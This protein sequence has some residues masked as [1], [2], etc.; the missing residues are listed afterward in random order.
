MTRLSNPLTN[1][2]TRVDA[3]K[4]SYWQVSFP[5]TVTKFLIVPYFH[6]LRYRWSK[7]K[8]VPRW[9]G[10]TK[11]HLW[12]SC[13]CIEGIRMCPMQ[14]SHYILLQLFKRIEQGEGNTQCLCTADINVHIPIRDT[15]CCQFSIFRLAL[16]FKL[17]FLYVQKHVKQMN[18]SYSWISRVLYLTKN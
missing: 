16:A 18:S 8:S 2:L 10:E 12:P 15:Y 6:K 11:M 4:N 3:I 14:V 5:N 9:I 13:A 17:K 1:D 7:P